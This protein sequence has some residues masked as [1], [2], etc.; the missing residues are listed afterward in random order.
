LCPSQPFPT[1]MLVM[2]PQ[3]AVFL[4][5]VFFLAKRSNPESQ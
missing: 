5:R 2:P 3:I 4:W 1:T